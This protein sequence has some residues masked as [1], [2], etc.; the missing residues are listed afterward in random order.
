MTARPTHRPNTAIA[1]L[2]LTEMGRDAARSAEQLAG[3]AIDR[4]LDDAGV[5][6]REI[7]GLLINPST[8]ENTIG[9]PLH[10]DLGFENLRLLAVVQA[11]GSS[12]GVM[13]A[14]A[15]MAIAAGQARTVVCVFAD[16]PLQPG[17]RAGDVYADP[18]RR[19]RRGFEG[20]PMASGITSP[21]VEY[22]L[23]ARRHMDTYGT[24]TEQLGAVAVST[25]QWATMNPLAQ[26]REPLTLSEHQQSRMIAAPLRKLDCCLLSN[27]AI[28]VVVTGADRARDMKQ[29]P[30][31]IRGWAQS[32]PGY[33]NR[34]DS[35]YGLVTGA[36]QSGA[37]AMA[38]AGVSASDISIRQLYDCYTFTTLISLEDYGFCEKGEGGPL[39]ASGALGP[40]GALPTN[41]GGGQL[42]G[43]Y[44]WGMTPLS[45]A[46]IQGRGSAAE[47]QV[48]PN[49]LILVSGNGGHLDLH[50]TVILSPHAD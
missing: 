16:V 47:R 20:L 30:V 41:T 4:A 46:V 5:D 29:P 37:D 35:T 49:D 23:A 7:D 17:I 33:S 21:N 45:E 36:K 38:M 28:A 44:M 50:S 32:A 2:G 22:A 39:A 25:R 6:V 42:S 18:A 10:R 8:G 31:Y 26:R 40:G 19:L 3:E 15:S 11:F 9:L 1:G 43:Y 14:H 48:L 12:A 34:P 13:I 27:G 24:T